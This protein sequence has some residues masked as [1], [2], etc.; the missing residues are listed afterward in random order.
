M[1][2][3]PN[4]QKVADVLVKIVEG[5]IRRP[6]VAVGDVFQARIAPYLSRRAPRAWVHWGLRLYYGLKKRS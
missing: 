5:K 2:R 4:P 3:A 6:V 1:N